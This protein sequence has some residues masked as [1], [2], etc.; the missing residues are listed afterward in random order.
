MLPSVV[1]VAFF[2]TSFV[3]GN[4]SWTNFFFIVPMSVARVIASHGFTVDG[5]V[6]R[7]WVCAWMQSLVSDI[8][9]LW[10]PSGEVICYVTSGPWK[11]ARFGFLWIAVRMKTCL[12]G[13]L[14]ATLGFKMFFFKLCLGCKINN[15]FLLCV[16]ATLPLCLQYFFLYMGK[17]TL[18]ECW[19]SWSRMQV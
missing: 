15:S 1:I 3:F 13:K 2:R 12:I 18:E 6:A 7:T 19:S 4:Y 11:D 16:M 8:S 17:Q 10:V 5:Y 14:W 9:C